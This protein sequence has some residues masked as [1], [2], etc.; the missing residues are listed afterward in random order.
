MN[1]RVYTINNTKYCSY[2]DVKKL[3]EESRSIHIYG[4]QGKDRL[5]I[6][7]ID[8]EWHICEHRKDKESGEV[9]QQTHKI[10]ELNVVNLWEIIKNRINIGEKTR[11]RKVVS[12]II[13]KNHLPL[14]L[15]E[16]NGGL[17]RSKYLFPLYY[18]PMKVLEHQGYVRYTGRGV[19]IRLK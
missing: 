14:T 18:Y 4:W 7:K 16:F 3:I 17:N 8:T 11:Y 5:N 15:D 6:V 2:E 1:I 9:A 19:I 12:D 13:L 10:P